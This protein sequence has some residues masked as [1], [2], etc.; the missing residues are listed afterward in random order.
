MIVGMAERK[1]MTATGE[2]NE[3]CFL[4]IS[5]GKYYSQMITF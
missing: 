5:Y 1:I 2:E 3:R 4:W